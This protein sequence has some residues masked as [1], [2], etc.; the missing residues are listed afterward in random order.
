LQ[1][2]T[3]N[4]LLAAQQGSVE[5]I[6]REAVVHGTNAQI[7]KLLMTVEPSDAKKHQFWA[8]IEAARAAGCLALIQPLAPDK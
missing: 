4:W 6:F 5:A 3:A 7:E 8:D 2:F 1:N